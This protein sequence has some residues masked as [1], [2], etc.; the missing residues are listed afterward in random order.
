MMNRSMTDQKLLRVLIVE[1]DKTSRF[2]LRRILEAMD[3]LE[4]YEAEDG[5]KAWE[6][7][8][9]GLLP[10]LCILDVNMPR[11]N[12]VELLKRIRNDERFR[13]LH[14]C[15][16]SAVRDRQLV[17]Q[18]AALQ[19]DSYILKPYDRQAIHAQVQKFRGT[20]RPEDSLEPLAGVCARLGI[21]QATYEHRL[22]ALI[23][24]VRTLTTRMPTLLMQLNMAGAFRRWT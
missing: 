22:S 24:D 14:A 15:F 4:I 12:G 6:L 2:V 7:L 17:V 11:M 19:P 8:D 16:C 23:E 1:D 9:C 10:Q 13:S 21:D 5:L 3:D 20:L 18:A